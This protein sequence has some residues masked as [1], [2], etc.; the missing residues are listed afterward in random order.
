MK[1][2]S[3]S[4]WKMKKEQ[5]VYWR[6]KLSFKLK[7]HARRK[8]EM[9]SSPRP[10]KTKRLKINA[11]S[12]KPNSFKRSRISSVLRTKKLRRTR[13]IRT[14]LSVN[15]K[16]RLSVLPSRS[17]MKKLIKKLRQR[18]MRRKSLRKNA[19]MLIKR[20]R[21][22]IKP[23]KTLKI[24]L[25]KRTANR[26]KTKTKLL[27]RRNSFLR[28]KSETKRALWL[29]RSL[30]SKTV[31]LRRL[32]K[33]CHRLQLAWLRKRQTRWQLTRTKLRKTPKTLLM[34]RRLR[35]SSNA[36][37]QLTSLTTTKT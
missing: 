3:A 37:S 36:S 20:L 5:N 24:N 7:T 33:T 17:L 2:L 15:K 22:L 16:M 14:V 34:A 28:S 30:Q 32:R 19:K 23:R 8:K 12:S 29:M 35:R 21:M 18:R 27:K 10:N 13:T 4:A 6:K 26:R 9:I 31:M 11:S 25:T 1:K